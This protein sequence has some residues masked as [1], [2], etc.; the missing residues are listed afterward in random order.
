MIKPKLK[1]KIKSVVKNDKDVDKI[2]D[3]IFWDL[4]KMINLK[5]ER[6]QQLIISYIKR[7]QNK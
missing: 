2:M 6:T 4:S 3:Y 7:C 1:D 5:P